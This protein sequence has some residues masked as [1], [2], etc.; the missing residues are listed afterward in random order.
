M[1]NPVVEVTPPEV[2]KEKIWKERDEDIEFHKQSLAKNMSDFSLEDLY[3]TVER[4]RATVYTVIPG[5]KLLGFTPQQQFEMS[6]VESQQK[7]LELLGQLPA[8]ADERWK[9]V[10]RGKCRTTR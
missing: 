4:S 9:N 2:W 7:Q 3:R 1:R 6:W 5:P 8:I 10:G